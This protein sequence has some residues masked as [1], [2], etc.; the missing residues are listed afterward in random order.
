MASDDSQGTITRLLAEIA[1]GKKDSE[2]ELFELVYHEIHLAAERRMAR[3]RKGHTWQPTDFVGE[4]YLRLFSK[5]TFNAPDRRYFFGA[6]ARAMRQ[7]LIDHSRKRRPEHIALD[8]MLN[9]LHTEQRVDLLDLNEAL[10]ELEKLHPRHHRVVLQKIFLGRS[11]D[12]IAKDEKCSKSTSEKD[13]MFARAW[14][15]QRLEGRDHG[16]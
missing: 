12:D 5:G 3:E 10:D 7:A 14:L 16:S 1:G 2:E 9:W 8:E 13:W 4:V 15:R 11:M 6:V